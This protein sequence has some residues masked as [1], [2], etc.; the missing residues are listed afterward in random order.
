MSIKVKVVNNYFLSANIPDGVLNM[1]KHKRFWYL[2]FSCA[3]VE[4]VS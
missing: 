1:H 2:L 4:N 3:N